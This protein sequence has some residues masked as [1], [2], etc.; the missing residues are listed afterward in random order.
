MI[1]II[2]KRH[3]VNNGVHRMEIRVFGLCVYA[4]ER[5]LRRASAQRPIGFVQFPNDAPGFI[6]DDEDVWEYYPEE[7]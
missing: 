7:F 3:S 6:D 5:P 2:L 1:T 4:T